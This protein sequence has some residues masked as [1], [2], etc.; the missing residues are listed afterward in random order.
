M[1][2]I[3]GVHDISAEIVHLFN[4]REVITKAGAFQGLLI[5]NSVQVCCQAPPELSSFGRDLFNP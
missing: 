3:G 5:I 2:L 4:C 1:I